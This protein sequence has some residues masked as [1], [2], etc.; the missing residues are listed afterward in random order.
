MPVFTTRPTKQPKLIRKK[1]GREQLWGSFD[2]GTNI[3]EVD[4]RLK[5]KKELIIMI[6][7][8]FHY[9]FP[10]LDEGEVVTKSEYLADFLWKHHFRKVDLSVD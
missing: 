6:H 5:G 7:E 3:I 4:D 10:G 1:L 8:Y 9:L 2:N